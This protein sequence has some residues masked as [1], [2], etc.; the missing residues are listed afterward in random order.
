MVTVFMYMEVIETTMVSYDIL[1]KQWSVIN[2]DVYKIVRS[3]N[4]VI[5]TDRRLLYTR[6]DAN[7][8][9]ISLDGNSKSLLY[10]D[11]SCNCHCVIFIYYY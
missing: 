10:K 2:N 1:T 3:S 11:I 6:E 7:V 4:S 8:Y 5:D 9:T